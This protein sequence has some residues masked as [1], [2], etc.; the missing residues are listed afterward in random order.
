MDTAPIP[1][2]NEHGREFIGI[3]FECCNIYQRVYKNKAGTAYVGHCPRCMR[4]VRLKVGESGTG[5]RFFRAQ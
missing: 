3:M 5:E 1:Q 4:Q 2:K